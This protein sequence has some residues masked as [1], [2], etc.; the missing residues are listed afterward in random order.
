MLLMREA[1]YGTTRFDDFARRVG[2]TDAVASS[3]LREL[4]DAGLL[5]RR[6]YREPGQRTRH[7]YVLTASGA[8]LLPV[9]L[10]LAEWGRKHAPRTHSPT[11]THADCGA[12]VTPAL[13]CADGHLVGAEDVI[14]RS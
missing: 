12:T 4:V 2:I 7:E 5:A 10:G 6:P 1:S 8:D 9:V 3:R 14:A 13:Q 11:F